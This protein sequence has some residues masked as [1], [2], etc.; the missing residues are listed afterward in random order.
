MAHSMKHALGDTEN[1]GQS[2]M[3]ELNSLI[4]DASIPSTGEATVYRTVY[5][6]VSGYILDGRQHRIR[7]SGI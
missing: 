6:A 2:A 3:A 1:H 5:V 7:G 4:S